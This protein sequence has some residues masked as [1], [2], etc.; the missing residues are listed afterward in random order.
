MTA[1]QGA[2]VKIKYVM[3]KI[4]LIITLMMTFASQ[5]SNAQVKVTYSE[6]YKVTKEMEPQM[7]NPSVA[8]IVKQQLKDMSKTSI[9]YHQSGKSIYETQ[10]NKKQQAENVIVQSFGE[11]GKVYKDEQRHEIISEES[12]LDRQFRVVEKL[13]RNK[14]TMVNGETKKIGNYTCRKAVNEVGTIAWYSPDIKISDGPSVYCGLP[15]LILEIE[16]TNKKIVLQSIDMNYS[17]NE[18]VKPTKGKTISRTDFAKLRDDKLKE[19]NV[20][21]GGSVKVV[22][23]KN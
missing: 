1:P 16:M 15:G 11:V 4:A 19:H 5:F 10:K 2:V 12:I 21:S 8:E 18:I 14:W 13:P 6:E 3:N 17:G 7:T 20:G 23:M 22:S 9:L